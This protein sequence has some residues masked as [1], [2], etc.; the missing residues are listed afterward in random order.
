VHVYRFRWRIPLEQQPNRI[1]LSAIHG[2]VQRIN[3]GPD[4]AGQPNAVS[5]QVLGDINVAEK[6]GTRESFREHRTL[7]GEP[8]LLVPGNDPWLQQR[9]PDF[10]DE[11]RLKARKIS[12]RESEERIFPSFVVG[13]AVGHGLREPA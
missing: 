6:A 7:I 4:T 3:A 1:E 5:K 12:A 2:P 10:T 13:D 8:P 11:E 9:L